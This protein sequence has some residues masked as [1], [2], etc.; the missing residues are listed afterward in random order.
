MAGMKP[1][2]KSRRT[3]EHYGIL[4]NQS[5]ANY[6]G[7]VVDDLISEIKRKRANFSIAE[8]SSAMGLMQRAQTMAGLRRIRGSRS[9]EEHRR[10]KI[11]KLVVCGGDGT[12][13]LA[14]RAALKANLPIGIIP[15][16]KENNI[17][18]SLFGSVSPDEGIQRIFS[19]SYK[20]IDYATVA[21]QMFFGSLG[22]GLIPNLE[23][24]LQQNGRPRFNMG[25]SS[26]GT[27]AALNCS[28][29]NTII[30]VDAFRFELSPL[31][32]NVNLLPYSAGIKVSPAS[33]TA[34]GLAEVIFD[35]NV[36]P[37]EAGKLLK[38]LS[39]Q[40]FVY[41]NDLRMYRGKIITIQPAEEL[42]L[43]LDGELLTLPTSI[44]EIEV[45]TKQLKICSD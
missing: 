20:S 19:K 42:L 15:L 30:K 6:D 7:R 3:T 14:A 12:F 1:A 25:W 31:I 43:Y 22:I 28:V 26:L 40:K 21:N 33:G 5:A 18:I 45:G 13:N 8:P 39:K 9:A 24:L 29:R 36:K 17:A 44:V 37:K 34:D 4:V 38:Q 16:G 11:T 23:R 27:K 2:R 32:F 10:G 35:I 41:G